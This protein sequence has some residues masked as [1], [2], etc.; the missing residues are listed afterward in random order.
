MAKG[1]TLDAEFNLDMK[2][3]QKEI[4]SFLKSTSSGTGK[5]TKSTR[6]LGEAF[7]G[8]SRIIGAATIIGWAFEAQAAL[9][10]VVSE[11]IDLSAQ[12]DHVNRGTIALEQTSG[13]SLK[14]IAANLR[15]A[16]GG[17][18]T[19][20][21]SLRQ[22]NQALLLGGGP[23]IIEE[24]PELFKIARVNAQAMGISVD[25]AIE[26]MVTGLGRVSPRWLD[27]LGI[28]IDTRSEYKKFASDAGILV[29]ALSE[30]DK[31]AALITAI[32][33]EYGPLAAAAGDN[34]LSAAESI[35][36]MASSWSNFLAHAIPPNMITGF[37]EWI[38]ATLNRSDFLRRV[39]HEDNIS[40]R[41][42][43]NNLDNYTNDMIGT[44]NVS[45]QEWQKIDKA[46]QAYFR[47]VEAFEPVE[48]QT[49]KFE[50]YV[51]LVEE[52][53]GL[54]VPIDQWRAHVDVF[55]ASAGAVNAS[56]MAI[57]AHTAEVKKNQRAIS[58]AAGA[59]GD[60]YLKQLDAIA[61]KAIKAGY[62]TKK[63]EE[64]MGY[65]RQTIQDIS[66]SDWFISLSDIERT[67][68][69]EKLVAGLNEQLDIADGKKVNVEIDATIGS[70]LKNV[71]Q[72]KLLSE[73][74]GG[75]VSWDEYQEGQEVIDGLAHRMEAMNAAGLDASVI[76]YELARAQGLATDQFRAFTPDVNAAKDSLKAY[77][78]EAALL[79][80]DIEKAATMGLEV[81]AEDFR[82]GRQD[83]PMEPVRRLRDV[84]NLGTESPWAK[85]FEIPQDVLDA[86]QE[87]VKAWAAGLA[88]RGAELRDINLIDKDAYLR[89]LADIKLARQ[90]R[91]NT[92][93]QLTQWAIDAGLAA[94]TKEAEELSKEYL[95]D[96]TATGLTEGFAEKLDNYKFAKQFQSS[97]EADLKKNWEK[98]ESVGKSMAREVF[99]GYQT[100]M[101]S[102]L[103]EY[104]PDP[105]GG[106][107]VNDTVPPPTG[108]SPIA[109]GALP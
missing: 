44:G 21:E 25:R 94:N 64:I 49:E 72:G 74:E 75:E 10:E 22:T 15:A 105:T 2:A 67:A 52:L 65:Y 73:V 80:A 101:D 50:H 100:E 12:L 20:T 71:L 45:V 6:E 93:A 8:I 96:P 56:A 24:L 14:S 23:A 58:D 3:A 106:S 43:S 1:I 97:F 79:Q 48:L 103:S 7:G 46:M 34:S 11:A 78:E 69:M 32:L 35:D 27:N 99:S 86:G 29:S 55:D 37:T 66:A 70:T 57:K 98:Y 76:A 68:L 81:R 4:D 19:L 83:S 63:L 59:V 18:I 41:R 53:A 26:S 87:A 51:G 47:S 88:D 39:T 109:A 91:A 89:E 28:I 84:A 13:Y 54:E 31:R 42:M 90:E 102:L 82:P 62:S 30:A 60:N 85:M 104:T 95:G 40:Y 61:L 77:R 36:K 17:T 9:R 92:M 33:R 5:A 108:T 38:A 107:G 16:A